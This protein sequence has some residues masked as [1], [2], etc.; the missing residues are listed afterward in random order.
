MKYHHYRP[1]KL[2][3]G[4]RW[5]IEFYYR[6]PAELIPIEGREW[7]RFIVNENINRYKD[8]NY[9][10]EVLRGV[11]VALERGYNP[12]EEAQINLALDG[13]TGTEAI[14]IKKA[15]EF[16]LEKYA[17]RGLEQTTVNRYGYAV[18]LIRSY[19]AEKNLLNQPIAKVRKA[20][21]ENLLEENKQVRKWGNRQYNNIK[22]FIYT[23]FEYLRKKEIIEKNPVEFIESLK[24]KSKKH[25]Y[26]D[27]Q[28]FPKVT[29]IIK[30]NDPYLWCAVQFVYYLCVRSEKELAAIKVGDIIEDGELFAFRAEATKSGRDELIPIDP[31]LKEVM[32]EMGLFKAKKT[33]YIFS[34]KGKPDSQPFGKNY[35][36]KKF[37]VIRKLAG[38]DEA[39]TLYSFRHSRCIHLVRA[40]VNLIDIMKMFRHSDIAATAKYVRALGL[41][42][43]AKDLQAKTQKI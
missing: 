2:V 40:G 41:E 7:K 20:H 24:S 39:Y 35:F 29:A 23:V 13:E 18:E 25:K 12:F 11:I 14:T 26:Y 34:I 17:K 21:I 6:V 4:K 36:A 8:D 28:L 43:N 1:P 10:E 27:K 9:A 42:I 22:G 31:N 38:L 19:F 37:R 3:K 5:Y 33:D 16:F 30:A 32:K 15:L